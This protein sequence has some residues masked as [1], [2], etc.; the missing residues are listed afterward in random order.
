MQLSK[1]KVAISKIVLQLLAVA[2][3]VLGI[4]L[5]FLASI[6][7]VQTMLVKLMFS[8]LQLPENIAAQASYVIALFGPTVASWGIL[9]LTLVNNYFSN[10]KN[11]TWFAMLAAI[12]V[13]Y[14]G[15]T[16]FSLFNNVSEALYVNSLVAM[17]LLIPLI[18]S[19]PISVKEK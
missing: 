7:A 10:P 14:I 12:M 11:T 8:G 19:Y 18:I 5:P 3:I 2:H 17:A 16:V 6:P 4:L 13:W 15:D 9:F 1:R